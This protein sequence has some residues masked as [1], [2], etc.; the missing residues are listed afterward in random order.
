M[1]YVQFAIKWLDEHS[2]A[3]KEIKARSAVLDFA[4]FLDAWEKAY[5]EHQMSLAFRKRR[6]RADEV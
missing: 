5:K 6:R 3:P 1:T 2:D 4:E